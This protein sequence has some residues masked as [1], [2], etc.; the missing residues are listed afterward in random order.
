MYFLLRNTQRHQR[1]KNP[2]RQFCE[3]NYTRQKS[4]G[5]AKVEYLEKGLSDLPA[6][7]RYSRVFVLSTMSTPN[8]RAAT[9]LAI[10]RSI[11]PITATLVDNLSQVNNSH[12]LQSVSIPSS[13]SNNNPIAMDGK[14]ISTPSQITTTPSASK[15]NPNAIDVKSTL[16]PSQSTATPS[17]VHNCTTI[18][19]TRMRRYSDI[20]EDWHKMTLAERLE[21][22]THLPLAPSSDYEWKIENESSSLNPWPPR[23]R[24]KN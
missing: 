1:Q 16:T 6:R 21:A 8:H 5:S 20:F 12:P 10:H 4:L 3:A 18:E 19:N 11:S 2:L 23:P 13:A 17:A 24:R 14:P 9:T 7:L 15:N 22:T